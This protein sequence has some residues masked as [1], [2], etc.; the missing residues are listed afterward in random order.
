MA[1][2][3]G[4]GS[5]VIKSGHQYPTTLEG[6]A[7][8]FLTLQAQ[9]QGDQ[10]QIEMMRGELFSQQSTISSMRA[11]AAAAVPAPADTST[12][13]RLP[14]GC[15]PNPP[16][17]FTG[18]RD[19]DSLDSW[20]FSVNSYLELTAVQ[21]DERRILLVGTY[22]QGPAQTWYR[23]VRGEKVPPGQ[24]ITTWAEFQTERRLNF[25][26]MNRV[27]IAR[28]RIH[29]LRQTGQLRDF[30]REF[31]NLTLDIAGM[32]EDEKL[33]RFVRGLTPYIRR[34]VE[35]QEPDSLDKAIKLSEKFDAVLRSTRPATAM[36][37]ATATT[38][39]A[40]RAAGQDPRLWS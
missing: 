10:A 23:G 33:D 24:R 20:L 3:G 21:G 28:D 11:A 1:Y 32:S 30:V 16:R 37:F 13:S 35:L 26:P 17:P 12:S 31:R 5:E 40:T 6:L 9:R 29:S 27:K 39:D 18:D 15:K 34:E 2:T 4:M 25:C 22:L 36:R 38:G 14:P 8:A 19:A 7:Q